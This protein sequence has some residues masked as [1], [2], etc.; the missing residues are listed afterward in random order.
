MNPIPMWTAIGLAAAVA[1]IPAAADEG[2]DHAAP[3][4]ASGGPALPRF[5]AVSEAFELVGV[6]NGRQLTLYLDRFADNSPVKDARLELD[7]GGTRLVARPHADGEYEATL[8]QALAPG[9]RAV[10]ATVVAGNETDLLAGEL[11]L[12][13]ATQRE[14]QLPRGWRSAAA[15]AAASI[16]ALAALAWA[17]RRVRAGG[18]A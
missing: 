12:H 7:L 17:V 11:D 14:A 2:H 18:A 1:A 6:L 16:A 9:V 5:A 4:A 15:W 13:E 3:A 8:A 10:T